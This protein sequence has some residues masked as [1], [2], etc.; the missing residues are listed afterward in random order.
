MQRQAT[1]IR[2]ITN[3]P[4]RVRIFNIK[5]GRYLSVEGDK[6]NWQNDDASL[7]IRDWMELPVRESPQVWTIIPF[8]DDMYHLVNQYSGSLACIRGRDRDNGATMI[9]YHNQ[10]TL[11]ENEPFQEWNFTELNNGNWLIKNA[12]SNKFVGPEDR[13]TSNDHY[14]VQW[15]NQTSEDSYQEWT[16]E[17]R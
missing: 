17:A 14:C 10:Y 12:N 8:R 11:P 13:S 4:L 9:Q 1:G 7:T 5:S 3:L 15:D 2:P 16:F 6:R